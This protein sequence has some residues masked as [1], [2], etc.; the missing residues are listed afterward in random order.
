[1]Q[2]TMF[3]SILDD[4]MKRNIA[5][6]MLR[7]L[8]P[9]GI[10]LWYD[11]YISKPTNPDTKGVSK[12]DQAAL[13]QPLLPLQAG[14]LSP[15]PGPDD[16]SLLSLALLSLGEDPA[17]VHPLPDRDPQGGPSSPSL[18]TSILVR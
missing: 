5:K 6:E 12:R 1:M 9:E 2:F 16:R 15:A 13:P 18:I 11:Y 8:K 3:T 17:F 14:Y 4:T 7:V 10:I